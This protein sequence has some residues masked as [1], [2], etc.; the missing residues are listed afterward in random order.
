VWE[1]DGRGGFH[2]LPQV[3]LV[4]TEHA[5]RWEKN[6]AAQALIL[7]SDRW[8]PILRFVSSKTIKAFEAFTRTSANVLAP[9]VDIT[10]CAPRADKRNAPTQ[11]PP[12]LSEMASELEETA[13]EQER[14][15]RAALSRAAE[16]RQAAN[17]ARRIARNQ[18]K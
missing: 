4:D 9:K 10:G 13:A 15:G 7:A 8:M 14:L 11:P 17:A 16:L 6:D 5:S 1:G 2:E 3:G 12:A 18:G